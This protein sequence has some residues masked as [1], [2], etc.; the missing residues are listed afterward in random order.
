MSNVFSPNEKHYGKF[1]YS[2]FGWS[3]RGMTDCDHRDERQSMALMRLH[4]GVPRMV[5]LQEVF[6][7]CSL[8]L[9]HAVDLSS[10]GVETKEHNEGVLQNRSS[11]LFWVLS[12]GCCC[13]GGSRECRFRKHVYFYI[14]IKKT[15]ALRLQ[16]SNLQM[17]TFPYRLDSFGIKSAAAITQ[18]TIKPSQ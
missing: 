8:V 15:S 12:V 16:S 11:G 2:E 10:V 7:S 5:V 1:T 13:P 18:G 9:C 17:F 6:P 4:I 3:D 14:G